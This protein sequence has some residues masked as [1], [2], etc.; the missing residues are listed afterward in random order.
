MLLVVHESYFE[1]HHRTVSENKK[2]KMFFPIT[3]IAIK[4][5]NMQM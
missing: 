2:K 1:K 5:H 4:F 3:N